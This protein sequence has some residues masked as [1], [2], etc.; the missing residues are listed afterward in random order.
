MTTRRSFIRN[1]SLLALAGLARPSSLFASALGGGKIPLTS[2]DRD[3]LDFAARYSTG[4]RLVGAAVLAKL[5]GGIAPAS[6]RILVEVSE[7][8]KLFSVFSTGPF[9]KARAEGN[10]VS[11]RYKEVGYILEN[12][13][14]DD[15]A[16]RLADLASPSNGQ[17]VDFAHDALVY[18]PAMRRVSDPH[19]AAASGEIKL[20]NSRLTGDA[21]LKVALR[22]IAEA[23]QLGLEQ[24]AQFGRWSAEILASARGC[25]P[26]GLNVLETQPA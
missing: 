2:A 1:G 4:Q 20:L 22:G 11:F 24:G 6:T 14:P 25:A 12:L 26:S 8:G 15:F 17:D 5:R 7:P 18:D 13:V 16:R 10:V 3:I 19:G 9:T 23:G 21:A